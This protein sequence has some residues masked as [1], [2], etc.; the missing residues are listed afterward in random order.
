MAN[1]GV[2]IDFPALSEVADG[3]RYSE[4]P[5]GGVEID[6]DGGDGALAPQ[7]PLGHGEN[8]ADAM[9]ASDKATLAAQVIEWVDAD[10]ES[11]KPW[12][13]RFEEGLKSLGIL[14]K[15]EDTNA[16]FKGASTVVHPILIQ[17][18]ALKQLY[19]PQGPVKCGV[20]GKK[21]DELQRQS[22]RCEQFMNYQITVLDPTYFWDV[23]QML[24]WLPM[25]GS[26][27][28]KSYPDSDD[29]QAFIRSVFVKADN[30]LVPYQATSLQDASR[31]THRIEC[32]HQQMLRWQKKGFYSSTV[33]LPQP[34]ESE[35]PQVQSSLDE[36]DAKERIIPEGDAPH[37]L[38]E[39]HCEVAVESEEYWPYIV[40][41]EEASQS[42]IGIRRNWRETDMS[43]R[44]RLWFTHYR[45]L[46]GLGFYGFGIVH[47]MGGLADAVTGT[48]RLLL[49]SGA[50]ASMQGGFKSKDAKLP[51]TVTLEPGVYKDVEMTSEELSKCFYTPN[52]KEPSQAVVDMHD[53]LVES[54]R[55]FGSTTEALVGDA[56]NT[57]PVGTTVALIEQS[58]EVFSGIHKRLHVAF[59]EEFRIRAELNGEHLPEEY[60]YAVAD[61][62]RSV[63]R[64]DFDARIDV[65]PVSDPNIYSSTQRIAIAQGELQLSQSAPEM[66]DT[67]EAH[68]RMLEA[69]RS[70][71]IDTLLP[72]PKD[73]PP[74][75][76]VSEGS[77]LIVGRPVRAHIEEDHAAHMAVHQAQLEWLGANPLA[78]AMLPAL[79][80]HISEHLAFAYRLQMMQAIGLVL[81][82]LDF[83]SKRREPMLSPEVENEIAVR[84][85]LAVQGSQAAAQAQAAATPSQ[86]Q[87][88][89]AERE[90][91]RDQEAQGKIQRDQ[92][93]AAAKFL[94]S[95]GVADIEPALLVDTAQKLGRSFD[96]VLAL[97]RQQ[98]S[99]GQNV[100]VAPEAREYAA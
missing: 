36:A 8:L 84:A 47:L 72:N 5:D 43:R 39:C 9:A 58:S 60:P 45:Y 13:T 38:Y 67:Y 85:A 56:K 37:V 34:M 30:I 53:R 63:L 33:M 97:I 20:L 88:Q 100:G 78:Q 31:I 35:P 10:K 99:G 86:A 91:L 40:T 44:R 32:S 61:S 3:T 41:V 23:D 89:S 1:A 76:P 83:T 95:R 71:D 64:R 96:E 19:P 28:K 77:Y 87:E 50:F 79:Q 24:F 2:V 68:R 6:L 92:L 90:G 98:Q 49:D 73:V 46:P 25:V 82:P 42:V 70:A 75:D 21:T 22:E 14:T 29:S 59:G 80:A 17:A 7:F 4:L 52:F 69:L 74:S 48:V 12:L 11:R 93:M 18:R 94:N 27:F 54:G 16:P 26:T 15:P 66:Y 65:I 57:G 81:P 51:G 55:R 62:E